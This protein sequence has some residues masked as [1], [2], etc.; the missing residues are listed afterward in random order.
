MNFL[1]YRNVTIKGGFW[2]KLREKNAR[3]SLNNIYRRFEE[4]G[5]FAALDCIK[6]DPPSHIFFDSDVAKWLESAAYLYGD[7]PDVRI[8]EI[9]GETVDKIVSAQLPSG[10]FNSFYQVYKPDKIFAERTEHE[11]YCAGHLIEAAVALSETGVN[12]KLLTAMRKYA[13][14]IY[15]RFYVVRDTGFTTCGH[16]EIELALVR[17]YLHTGEE[18]YLTLAKFFLDERGARREEIYAFADPTYDQSHLP[19][20]EQ[21]EAV[22]HAVRALYLYIAMSEVGRI[23]HDDTLLASARNLFRSVVDTKMY[24][25]G[26]TGSLYYGERFTAPYDLPNEYAY[27]ETCSAIALA[28]FCESLSAACNQ[29]EYHDVFERVVYNNLLAG[30]SADGKG[31]FYTNPLE[32][33]LSHVKFAREIKGHP[34]QPIVERVEV[35][36]CSCCPPNVTRFLGR[37]GG[38]IYAE[39]DGCVYIHQYISS[40]ANVGGLHISMTSEFPYNGKTQITVTGNGVLKLR[41]PSWC[42]EFSCRLNGQNAAA[43][44]KDGYISLSVQ[45]ETDIGLDFCMRPRFV[46]ANENVSENGGRKAVQYGPLVLCA[47]GVDNGNNLR[48]IVIPSP[49]H[50]VVVNDGEFSVTLPAERLRTSE[51]LYSYRSPEKEKITLKLIPYFMW[52]NRGETDMQIWFL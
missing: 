9:V 48:N 34:Y 36:D 13:D 25:T 1:S 42:D 12:L 6:R 26:G 31:F 45:G 40:E 30:E 52:A 4:T 49:E 37:I 23:A 38:S 35:F 17:L 22:G 28:L 24:V 33:N 29:A 3:V 44:G 14:Y 27:S 47:E 8:K 46:Y 21:T 20:R 43:A 16:P 7:Y 2:E 18:K 19:V 10:Y 39:Q 32:A 41:I 11:L 50:A 51:N 5:R 15:E